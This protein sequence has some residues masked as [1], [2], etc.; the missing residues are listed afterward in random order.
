MRGLPSTAPVIG[1]SSG[2]FNVGL[3]QPGEVHDGFVVV[4]EA[5]DHPGSAADCL[6]VSVEDGQEQVVGPSI[7]LMAA[8]VRPIFLG[9]GRCA[10]RP[11]GGS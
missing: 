1:S 8:R 2:R 7:R 4:G 5:D 9:A 10:P 6:K 11:L 3:S